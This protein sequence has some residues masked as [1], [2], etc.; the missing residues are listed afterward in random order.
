MFRSSKIHFL[1]T[2]YCNGLTILVFK[3]NNSNII[4]NIGIHFGNFD[5]VRIVKEWQRTVANRSILQSAVQPIPKDKSI[6]Q[7]V[8]AVHSLAFPYCLTIYEYF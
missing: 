7:L 6:E 1:L 8:L 4:V 3:N 5:G 2:L